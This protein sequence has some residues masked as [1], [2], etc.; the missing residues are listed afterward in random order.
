LSSFAKPLNLAGEGKK[1]VKGRG[2]Q[3]EGAK[4]KKG[5]ESGSPHGKKNV[6]SQEKGEGAGAWKGREGKREDPVTNSFAG[7]KCSDVKREKEAA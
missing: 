2:V 3:K 5:G 7:K 1:R 4:K 6:S